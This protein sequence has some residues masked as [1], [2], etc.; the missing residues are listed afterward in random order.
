MGWNSWN[1]FACNINEQIFKDMADK[2]IELGLDKL[3]YNYV[4]LDDC[5]Q[6]VNRTK[7]GHVIVD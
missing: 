2:I 5:W 3:G 1:T 7:D 4:N 6:A